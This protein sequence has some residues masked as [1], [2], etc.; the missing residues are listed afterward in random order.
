[1]G[2]GENLKF[3]HTGRFGQYQD[4]NSWCRCMQSSG[5]LLIGEYR[6][7]GFY[8]FTSSYK[9]R[10]YDAFRQ[11]LARAYPERCSGRFVVI[12]ED[13]FRFRPLLYIA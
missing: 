1:V 3:Y 11:Y 6:L 10:L 4:E 13:K 8:G 12:D 9:F 5:P 7:V 2:F